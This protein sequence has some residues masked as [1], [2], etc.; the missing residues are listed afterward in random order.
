MSPAV[1]PQPMMTRPQGRIFVAEDGPGRS[2]LAEIMAL[3][4]V[5][6]LETPRCNSALSETS[7][8]ASRESPRCHSALSHRSARHTSRGRASPPPLPSPPPAVMSPPVGR[9][10]THEP[11]ISPG[12]MSSKDN[13]RAFHQAWADSEALVKPLTADAIPSG[14][15]G[16]ISARKDEGQAPAPT[17]RK[18]PRRRHKEKPLRGAGGCPY[19]LPPD[20]ENYISPT[21]TSA[22]IRRPVCGSAGGAKPHQRPVFQGLEQGR[23]PRHVTQR[24]WN[25]HALNYRPS[26]TSPLPGTLRAASACAVHEDRGATPRP[27]SV[28]S[29][30]RPATVL[31]ITTPRGL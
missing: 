9:K 26:A 14:T 18:A 2:V 20:D 5:E 29:T 10:S 16:R 21:T 7:R 25:R 11:P 17:H 13:Q 1:A 28:A 23:I 3:C 30:P 8:W 31:G 27:P 4:T 15:T 24:A 22:I 19:S 6:E 12:R